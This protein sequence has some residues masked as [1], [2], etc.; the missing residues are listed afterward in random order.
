MQALRRL[1][2]R[3][4]R[5]PLLTFARIVC[6]ESRCRSYIDAAGKHMVVAFTYSESV[7]LAMSQPKPK[8]LTA[9]KGTLVESVAFDR[10]TLDSSGSRALEFLVGSSAGVIMKVTLEGGKEKNCRQVRRAKANEAP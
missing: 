9:L 6:A 8:L 5:A 10:D 4:V 1:H 3:H 7:Y 2:P